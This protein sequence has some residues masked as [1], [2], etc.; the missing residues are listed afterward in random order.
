MGPGLPEDLVL[1]GGGG[2]GGSKGKE[3]VWM[4]KHGVVGYAS[5]GL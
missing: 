3:A 4:D 2:E 1:W 5:R